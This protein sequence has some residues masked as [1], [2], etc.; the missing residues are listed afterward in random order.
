MTVA[1]RVEPAP[2]A[3]SPA[4]TLWQF[5]RPH[6]ITATTASV[7]TLWLLAVTDDTASRPSVLNLVAT[8]LV[9]LATNVYITGINQVVD[10]D[11]DRI[12]K[13]RLPLAAGSMTQRQGVVVSVTCGVGALVAAVFMSAALTITVAIGILVGTAYSIPP[14]RLKRFPVPAAVSIVSVR[15]LVLTIGVYVHFADA[16][17]IPGSVVLLA[18]VAMLFG[19]VVAVLKDLP[20]RWGD[21]QFGIR[22]FSTQGDVASVHRVAMAVIVGC[23]CGAA[24]AGPWIAGLSPWVFVPGELG[25]AALSVWTWRRTDPR[26]MASAAV[27]YRWVWRAYYLH[28]AV[29]AAAAVVFAI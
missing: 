22:T 13:P 12:N 26:D 18:V 24:I 8:L 16:G 7:L 19:L 28:H 17:A 2:R 21:A 15:G 29:V 5:T 25:C 10:V 1:G 9:C 3:V 20:D 23:Y 27:G 14:A 6:T 4:R 11:I